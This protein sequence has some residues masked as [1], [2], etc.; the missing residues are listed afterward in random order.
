MA[1]IS[2]DSYDKNKHFIKVI[3][4]IGKPLL[5]SE[6]NEQQEIFK[7]WFRDLVKFFLRA[8]VEKKYVRARSDD[9]KVVALSPVDWAVK[10]QPGIVA[11]E[12]VI[13]TTS[14]AV[15]AAVP[16]P[17]TYDPPTL[18][19]LYLIYGIK[20]I[21]GADDSDI[22]HPW[23]GSETS[24]RLKLGYR[25]EALVD[26]NTPT[27]GA[28]D[29]GYVEI[30]TINVNT[31]G[32]VTDAMITNTGEVLDN[33]V[34]L[35]Y[36]NTDT[37]TTA[38]DFYVGGDSSTG[39]KVLT[40]GELE[41]MND[42]DFYPEYAGTI[43]E[44]VTGDEIIT[45]HYASSDSVTG[46]NYYRLPHGSSENEGIVWV[47]A[48]VPAN[49]DGYRFSKMKLLCKVNT[50]S[51]RGI[52]VQL[53]DTAGLW[54]DEHQIYVTAND[55]WE[56]VVMDVNTQGTWEKGKKFLVKIDLKLATLTETDYEDIYISRLELVAEKT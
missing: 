21:S 14:E 39:Q 53:Q 28:D 55:D 16:D 36:Q 31:S 32:G 40:E 46:W 7:E 33:I 20:E 9:W 37:H 24:R 11:I 5:D 38:S 26:P 2:Q 4:Q 8:A 44:A 45:G 54:L 3:K 13:V 49:F 15:T 50:V 22:I 17:G 12:N 1:N 10:I 43:V 6:S 23:I 51:S 56:E 34:K 27:L 29:D 30:A 35:H 19:D 42:L 18:Y 25:F 52:Y 48:E 41:L 47:D